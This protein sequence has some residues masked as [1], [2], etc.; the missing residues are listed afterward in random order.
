MNLIA[1]VLHLT[2]KDVQALKITNPYA[3]HLAVYK[4]FD[5]VR[6]SEEKQ[7]SC[8]SGFLYADLGGD[9]KGRKILLLSNRLPSS[10]IDNNYGEVLSKPIPSDFLTYTHYR[11]KVI[12]NPTKRNSQSRKLE[13]VKGRQAISEWF[14]QRAETSWG[15]NASLANLQVDAT[16]LLEFTG[17]NNHRI[18]LAQ[19]SIQGNLKVTN[20]EQ[21]AQS[22]TQGIGRAR[23]FGCGLL[24][25]VPIVTNPFDC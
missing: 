24:Q 2:R 10:K 16:N 9:Y 8:P 22:F 14:V 7:A 11:F 18:T 6:T 17:K 4:L 20:P 23:A 3:L 12:I 19:T 5:D 13:A 25:L 1:S 21:F 15:F